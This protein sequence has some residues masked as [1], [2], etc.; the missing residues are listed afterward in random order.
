MALG[1]YS[2]RDDVVELTQ[3]NFKSKVIDSDQ[4]WLV[5][6]YAPWCGHCKSMA[7]D[8]K[9]AATELKGTVNVG[10]V[11]MT[12]HQS[13][14]GPYGVQGFPTIK[15]F[16]YD[17][18]K[19]IDY[20]GARNADAFVDEAFKQLRKMT[21]DKA[22]GGKSSGSG[23]KKSSGSGKDENVILTDSNF[24][25]KV[26]N[27]G[28]P[29][30]VEFFAPWCGHCQRLAP[31]W[32]SA[33]AD[34]AA[35][36]GGKVKMGTV[37]ATVEQQ[38]AGQYG[39]QGYPTIKIFYPD[40]RVEDFQGGRTAAD[41]VAQGMLLFE[42]VAD[43]PELREL[44]DEEALKAS[45]TDVQLCFIAFFPDILDDQAAGR[46]DRI[47]LLKEFI[48]NYKR[49]QWGWLWVTAFNQEA[50]QKAFNV[51]D[52]PAVIAINQRKN[53]AVK[54]LNSFSKDGLTTFFRNIAYGKTGTATTS[55]S[56]WPEIKK[57]DP[58]DGKDGV[59]EDD[60]DDW[61]LDDFDWGDDEEEDAPKDEL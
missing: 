18:K 30:L 20:K 47:K 42:D 25:A 2:G 12:Q 22:S 9:K 52:F 35:K 45:C 39:I 21:K 60:S 34:L 1:L 37:D 15:I 50:M 44:V 54:M 19:P 46:N 4:L 27:G 10:A 8:Y 26:L 38:T 31:E 6:F 41:L 13:V 7:N 14:G 61:D 53:I 16:G 5:E 3:A 59:L 24:R 43:P 28:Q 40:G 23:G 36:T 32:K 17:K 58:W 49:K 57:R 56:E 48:D 33:A 51:Q 29:W 55:F 11:D